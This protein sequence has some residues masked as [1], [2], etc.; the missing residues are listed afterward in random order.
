MKPLSGWWKDA[1]FK[2]GL[3][4][5]KTALS[6]GL[7]LL[8]FQ[9]IGVSDGIQA[10]ITAIICMKSSLQNS[11]QVGVE[12]AIG[13]VIGAILGILT[14]IL[15]IET[16]LQWATILAIV[17]VILIIYL[18]NIFKVQNS[19]IISLV[20]FLMIL[21]GEKDQPPLIYGSMR[22][23]ETIFGIGIAYLVSLFISTLPDF[24]EGVCLVAV[25]TDKG[26]VF[27]S[28]EHRRNSLT[29]AGMGNA[30]FIGASKILKVVD[31][32]GK[33][34]AEFVHYPSIL[35]QI[36][37]TTRCH[38]TQPF[39]LLSIKTIFPW[40]ENDAFVDAF[41]TTCTYPLPTFVC[42]KAEHTADQS[43]MSPDFARVITLE[44]VVYNQTIT[45]WLN[46]FTHPFLLHYA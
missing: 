39:E 15:M 33:M 29:L 18:C 27:C 6:V 30:C 40:S 8:V 31:P 16:G 1:R 38:C 24:L 26:I 22:L 13:T 23:V 42:I 45:D 43:H 25:C 11:L 10:A 32:G 46:S 3:R 14:L 19:T 7:C 35:D 44:N 17:N 28:M 41:L 37:G 36:Q 2:I 5:I 4:N 9:T 34:Q 20:V 21:I 12:R